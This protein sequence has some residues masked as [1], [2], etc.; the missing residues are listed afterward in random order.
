MDYADLLLSEKTD[1]DD[2]AATIEIIRRN[3]DKIKNLK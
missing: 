3:A 2:I 1:L